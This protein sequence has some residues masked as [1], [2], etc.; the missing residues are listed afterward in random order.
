MQVTWTPWGCHKISVCDCNEYRQTELFFANCFGMWIKRFKSHNALSH[1][2]NKTKK[3][4][5]QESEI[6][7]SL[8]DN[9]IWSD[10][11]GDVTL[12][13]EF[14]LQTTPRESNWRRLQTK[15]TDGGQKTGAT[16]SQWLSSSTSLQFQ[17]ACQI[18]R[19]V[20]TENAF[21]DHSTQW[22]KHQI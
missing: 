4:N 1:S 14:I 9:Q 18:V 16:L 15:M 21:F 2:M 12:M 22:N 11:A 6:F 17:I 19:I 13:S 5:K 20:A 8:I 7:F 10:Q 3:S